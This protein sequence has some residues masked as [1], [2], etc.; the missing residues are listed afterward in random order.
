MLRGM[1]RTPG[2]WVYRMKEGMGDFTR[3]KGGRVQQGSFRTNSAE[4]LQ[5]E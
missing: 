4:R 2:Y 5:P 1:E 3:S